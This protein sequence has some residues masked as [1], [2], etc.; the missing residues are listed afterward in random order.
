MN[1]NQAAVVLRPR[2]VSEVL[3][4]ACLWLVSRSLAMTLRLSA[5][6]LL[7][8]FVIVMVCRYALQWPPFALWLLAFA[9]VTPLEGV[10]TIAA[11]RM[12][13]NEQLSVR[14]VLGLYRK[15]LG[16]YLGAL[17]I[18]R[19]YIALASLLIVPLPILSMRMMFVHEAALLEMASAHEATKRSTR[20]A[21]LRTSGA[22]QAWF[23]LLLA[24]IAVVAVA[25]IVGQGIVGQLLQLGQPFG[26]LE[27][28]W[29]TPFALLGLLASVPYVAVA[30]YL[31]Y[32]DT[33]TRTD[34]WDIQVRFFAIAANEDKGGL[35][36]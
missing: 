15:R 12:L 28:V 11:G 14:Q 26:A 6:V 2:K 19:F 5:V 18:S 21:T 31:L 3:D 23:A 24:Q 35:T 29:F 25:E 1:L 30:R 10:F 22:F 7:P 9:L 27:K 34:G 16:A 36:T 8:V 33:R 13:F 20:L 17:L 4:L 32:I